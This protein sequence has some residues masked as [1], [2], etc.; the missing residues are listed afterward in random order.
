MSFAQIDLGSQ[1]SLSSD[2]MSRLPSLVGQG[3]KNGWLKLRILY[4]IGCA[5]DV[6]IISHGAIIVNEVTIDP[7]LGDRLVELPGQTILCDVDGRALGFFSPLHDRPLVADL[8]LEPP[9][10]IAETEQLRK[11]QSGKPLEEILNR[12]GIQ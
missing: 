12:L 6:L 9:L 5:T 1:C 8:Q 4:K 3:P 10:S 2:G 7:A 11:V